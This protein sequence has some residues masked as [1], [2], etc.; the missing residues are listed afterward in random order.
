MVRG[1]AHRLGTSSWSS[2]IVEARFSLLI[3]TDSYCTNFSSKTWLRT[4]DPRPWTRVYTDKK[5]VSDSV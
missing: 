4:L 2:F 1:S 3:Q 5:E